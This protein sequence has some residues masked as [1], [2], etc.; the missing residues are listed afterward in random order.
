MADEQ[1]KQTQ[2]IEEALVKYSDADAKSIGLPTPG[3][4][5]MLAVFCK[6][7]IGTP[8]LPRSFADKGNPAG[9]LLAV[10]LT[11]HEMGFSPMQAIRSYWLSP[12][13]RLGMY[14]DAM[15]AAMLAKGFQANWERLDNEGAV[16][17][18]KRPH[19]PD[20]RSEF[21]IED[22]KRAGIFQKDKSVWPKYPK[23]MCKARVIGDTFRTLAPDL[24]GGQMYTKEEIIDLEPSES[25]EYGVLDA[26]PTPTYAVG[27][28]TAPGSDA[29]FTAAG[30][31]AAGKQTDPPAADSSHVGQTP[32]PD[33][34]K[35]P[36]T[37]DSAS[38]IEGEKQEVA[39]AKTLEPKKCAC[40]DG[41]CQ[42]LSDGAAPEGRFC[43]EGRD[44]APADPAPE[45]AP[46]SGA[47][48]PTGSGAAHA[49]KPE[50]VPDSPD[51]AK[52]KKLMEE[53]TAL[54]DHFPEVSPKTVNSKYN[55]FFRGVLDVQ[56]LPKD[57]DVYFDL[58]PALRAAIA[59]DKKA[60]WS[61]PTGAG[62]IEAADRKFIAEK[63]AEWKW[64]HAML[65][66]VLRLK[67]FFG[68][69]GGTGHEVCEYIG[70]HELQKV[71]VADA[72]AFLRMAAVSREV[73]RIKDLAKKADVGYA[74]ILDNMQEKMDKPIDQ[75]TEKEFIG[76]LEIGEKAMAD[77]PAESSHVGHGAGEQEALPWNTE[78]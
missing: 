38:S 70:V 69:N 20:Y 35:K 29:E 18:M 17:L 64:T 74:V 11:G 14:A 31:A 51:Q 60:L 59:A 10:V 23:A 24:G 32:E 66:V 7:M 65:P 30:K 76:L 40:V 77:K 4:L 34:T 25:G 62:R 54:T 28:K 21:T 75:F 50:L 8:F 67:Y 46:V 47:T 71:S 1:P 61:D 16:L 43:R 19:A 41:N 5:N 33:A 42:F 56:T 27:R 13:G 37:S 26:E 39:P 53:L 9:T 55:S 48:E 73:Y 12:D 52:R 22:A 2:T 57:P 3:A 78:E 6:S 36:A 72:E 15:M 49:P 63:I 45:I 58:L 44:K 68:V